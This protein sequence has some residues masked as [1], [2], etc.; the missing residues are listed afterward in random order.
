MPLLRFVWTGVNVGEE[1]RDVDIR[2]RAGRLDGRGRTVCR[3]F[4]CSERLPALRFPP[5][6]LKCS[7]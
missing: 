3:A 2:A 5:L 7:G 6:T 1:A 4:C